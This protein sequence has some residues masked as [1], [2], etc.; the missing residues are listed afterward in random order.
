VQFARLGLV[1]VDEQHRFGVAQRQALLDKGEQPDLLVMTAT[2]IPRTLTLTLY[3]DLDLS[4]IDEMPPGRGR[5]ET[6]LCTPMERP[7]LYARVRGMASAGGRAY[8]IAPVIDE[9]DAR[10]LRAATVLAARL[11]RGPLA[12]IPLGL[13][14]GRMD[15]DE[16]AA[17]MRRFTEGDLHVLVATS[18]VEV[19]I[20]VPEASAMVIENAER[21][22]LTQLHQLRGR[23]GRGRDA[24]WCA[25]APSEGADEEALDR[26]RV[27]IQCGDGFE[28]AEADLRLRGSGELF[29]EKQSGAGEL[30]LA[31]LARHA[32]LVEEAR[33]E[34]FLWVD[35]TRAS[36]DPLGDAVLAEVR[37]RW[38]Q[39][40][41]GL[42]EG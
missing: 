1:V 27:F 2:P 24:S 18:L 30:R 40:S 12:G 13:L 34:A 4:V 5:V 19:G 11:E 21:F 38:P 17:V 20:D 25:L 33:R 39:E 10:G 14:H 36:G 3:G 35:Q 23:I 6:F 42:T 28:V 31:D 7:A 9:G 37:R 32:E 41:R 15:P 26:L 16:K 22:G 8:V 29:G